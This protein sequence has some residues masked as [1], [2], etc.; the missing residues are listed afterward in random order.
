MGLKAATWNWSDAPHKHGASGRPAKGG[1]LVET[2]AATQAVLRA[3]LHDI[4]WF[5][6]LSTQLDRLT[7]W[8][9]SI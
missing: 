6:F 4:A 8:F 3:N 1:M 2:S 7:F 9:G 5:A